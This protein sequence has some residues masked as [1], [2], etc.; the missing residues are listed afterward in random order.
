MLSYFEW[1]DGLQIST[2]LKQSG[3][4]FPAIESV[5]IVAVTLVVGSIWIVDLRLLGITSR[6]RPVTALTT[7]ILPWTWGFYAVGFVTGFLMFLSKPVSYYHDNYFWYL[8]LFNVIAAIN[9]LV[10]HIFAYHSVHL[11]DRDVP[12]IVG[13]K[14]AGILSILLWAAVVFCGRWIGYTLM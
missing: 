10:F 11:W 13:A 7:E 4:M 12:T 3:W 2:T 9:M 1:L 5:H 14:I 8:L 6:K